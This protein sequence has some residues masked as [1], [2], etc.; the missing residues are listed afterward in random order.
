VRLPAGGDSRRADTDDQAVQLYLAFP[1]FPAAVRSRIIGYVWDSTAPAGGVF[2]SATT[3][4]VTY[5]VVRSGPSELDR[6]ITE[7][8]NVREDF[9]RIYGDEPTEQVEAVTI[10]I[11]SNDTKSR[12]ESFMGEIV[13][14]RQ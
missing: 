9:L 6:W 8:R 2:R 7:K 12:A 11:D 13:F 14:S 1:R 5:V 10:A 4:L 3:R